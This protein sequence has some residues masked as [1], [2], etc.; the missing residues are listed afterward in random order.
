V[1]EAIEGPPELCDRLQGNQRQLRVLGA[2]QKGARERRPVHKVSIETRSK[3]SHTGAEQ[4]ALLSDYL[5]R[6][7]APIFSLFPYIRGLF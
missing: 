4:F 7:G 3:Q 1:L 6:G 5:M 2:A